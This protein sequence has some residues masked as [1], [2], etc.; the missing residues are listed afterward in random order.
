MGGFFHIYGMRKN[1]P[2]LLIFCVFM[3]VI[4]FYYGQNQNHPS[5]YQIQEFELIAQPDEV[6]CGPTSA[7]MVLKSYDINPS[8]R[9]VSEKTKTHW[10]TYKG[11]QIGATTLEYI[12][13]AMRHFG[14]DSEI[15]RGNVDLLKYYVSQ[16]R[17]VICH[18]RTGRFMSHFLVVIGF[19]NNNII[20]ADPGNGVCWE[21]PTKQFEA[22]WNFT[23][24]L[25]GHA[26]EAPCPLCKGKG[27]ISSIPLG[28]IVKCDLC[29]G[30][31]N[32]PDYMKEFYRLADIYPSTMIVPK[33]SRK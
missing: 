5:S 14:L 32:D 10:F 25:Y 2:Q 13:L 18:V 26:T 22:A 24:D 23:A 30:T 31:G 9:E 16:N 7:L 1:L 11:R 29:A 15:I 20:I 27:R 33:S 6:T 21:V 19:D 17:P 12:V 8:L 28:P 4:I 3:L